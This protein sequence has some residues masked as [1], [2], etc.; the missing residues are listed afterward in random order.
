M[1]ALGTHYGGTSRQCKLTCLPPWTT[2]GTERVSS[3]W[4]SIGR[5]RR[6]RSCKTDR[7]IAQEMR[8]DLV[9]GSL[10]NFAKALCLEEDVQPATALPS[11]D[12]FDHTSN[13]SL[14]PARAWSER[15]P[16]RGSRPTRSTPLSTLACMR[17]AFCL[18]CGSHPRDHEAS[19]EAG[20]WTKSNVHRH[21]QSVSV[22]PVLHCSIAGRRR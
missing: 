1:L 11:S 7:Q 21:L 3:A 20:R 16:M 15:S 14:W 10:V 8:A 2:A 18:R 5:S 6:W 9:R 22:V 12:C 19:K 4:T 17:Q 13:V